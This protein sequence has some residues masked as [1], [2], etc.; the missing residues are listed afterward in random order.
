M[1]EIVPLKYEYCERIYEIAKECLPEHWSLAG[2]RDVL[3]YD[4]NIYYVAVIKD[5]D[6][7]D[8]RYSDGITDDD[9][10]NNGADEIIDDNTDNNGPDEIIDDNIDDSNADEITDCECGFCSDNIVGFGGIMIVADEAEL[11]N[12][13]V[14]ES[15]RGH[16][17]ATV[18]L[19]KLMTDAKN[20]GC[21]GMLLEV[22]SHNCAAQHLYKKKGFTELG[23]R[24][25]YYS[26]P[27]DDAIIMERGL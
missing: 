6:G 8:I 3:N 22:R 10:D 25:N 19:D 21:T 1:I 14:T 2:I 27:A 7:M 17:I 12:V 23:V 4:N 13:A 15:L 16:G 24:K 18:L 5:N 9:I 11:L 20:A 26:N